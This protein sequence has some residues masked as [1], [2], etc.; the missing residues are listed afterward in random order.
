MITWKVEPTWKKSVVERNYL[1]KDDNTVMVETG[2]RWGSFYVYTDDDNPPNIESGVDIY[3]C[4]YESELIETFDGNWEDYD[5][6][7]CDDETREWLEEFFD[8]GNSWLDLECDH[9]WLQ[10]E[11]EMIIDCDLKI[12]RINDD[13]TEGES[14]TTGAQEE[15]KEISSV[16]L[17]PG[18]AWPFDNATEPAQYAE[19]K[20]TNCDFVTDDIM[21]L[22]ENPDEDSEGAFVCPK[23]GGKVDL[24]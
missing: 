12:T 2:W 22:V 18:A 9:G 14:F 6:D 19:F 23:C 4:G 8:E 10:D 3:N 15:T 20:C 11:C 5:F 24:Q 7:D 13:G 16:E 17:K 21:E 1:T